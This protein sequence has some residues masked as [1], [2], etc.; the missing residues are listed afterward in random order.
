AWH[1]SRAPAASAA[2]RSSMSISSS[3]IALR[4]FI[5]SR[6]T[7]WHVLQASLPPHSCATATPSSSSRSS[8]TSPASKVS[9]TVST[10][11]GPP[12]HEKGPDPFS[13][14]RVL[15][16]FSASA[17]CVERGAEDPLR[18]VDDEEHQHHAVDGGVERRI[19]VAEGE[20]QAFGE[21]QRE[22]GA[23]RRAEHDEHPPGDD[24]EHHLQAD[25]D[26][27]DRIG[28]YVELVLRVED[29]AGAGH[30]RRDHGNA[31]LRARDV[32]AD[33]GSGFLL[34][35]DRLQREPAHAAID[36]APHPQPAEPER[37]H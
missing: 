6:T 4:C 15:T 12:F 18:H 34:L 29:A 14:K 22:G 5:P 17:K 30:Q 31:Q 35:A 23:D 26:A 37:S 9:V 36:L 27:G 11:I 20:P 13:A 33:G 25:R 10:P 2:A 21:K 3:L 16:P 19:T 1:A 8:S 28:V 32:D 7:T 24:A